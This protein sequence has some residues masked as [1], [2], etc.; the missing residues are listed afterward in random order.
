MDPGLVLI[1]KEERKKFTNYRR[2]REAAN[3]CDSITQNCTLAWAEIEIGSNV[4]KEVTSF[5]LDPS[6]NFMSKQTFTSLLEVY[7]K[8]FSL[9]ASR[10]KEFTEDMSETHQALILERNTPLLCH[11]ILA[12]CLNAETGFDQLTWLLGPYT[13]IMGNYLII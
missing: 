4:I 7:M 9:F 2:E 6:S 5:F 11:F 12:G 8:H 10:T 1:S 3:L 13:P